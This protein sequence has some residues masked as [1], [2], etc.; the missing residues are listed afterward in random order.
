[1]R[2]LNWGGQ[3]F[4]LSCVSLGNKK[5]LKLNTNCWDA[6]SIR[7]LFTYAWDIFKPKT[8]LLLMRNSDL[9]GLEHTA[10]MAWDLSFPT[11]DR[12]V[13]PCNMGL[14]HEPSGK[15]QAGHLCLSGK[16]LNRTVERTVFVLI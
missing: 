3:I 16:V 4:G 1:M 11:K 9:T 14:N 8:Y 13:A 12:P 15:F 5:Y 6:A 2:G 7:K 10:Y